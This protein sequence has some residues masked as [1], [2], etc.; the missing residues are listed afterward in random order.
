MSKSEDDVCVEVF[1]DSESKKSIIVP[2]LS[3][4][5]SM[6][7]K[8]KRR[9]RAAKN[10]A[11]ALRRT[12]SLTKNEEQFLMQVQTTPEKIKLPS[13]TED[14]ELS[15][16]RNYLN[17]RIAD[18]GEC[19]TNTEKQFLLDLMN[20]PN[21]TAS[22]LLR[23]SKVLFRDPLFNEEEKKEEHH[24]TV[25][26][27]SFS[28]RN[29]CFR[30]EVWTH[31]QYSSLKDKIMSDLQNQNFSEEL[32]EEKSKPKSP[33]KGLMYRLMKRKKKKLDQFIGQNE[34]EAS[35]NLEFSILGTFALDKECEPHVLSPPMMDVLRSHLPFS[36]KQ[37]NF[38]LKYSLVR[39][40]SSMRVLLDKIRSS[41]RTV[42]AIETVQGDV[43]GSF[44]SSP[45]RPRGK[46]FYGSCEAFLWRMKKS[47]FSN[48]STVD[49]QIALE[50]DLEIFPW[51]GKNRNVQYFESP[52]GKI[53]I[54]GGLPDNDDKDQDGG[55]GLMITS[56]MFHG[57]SNPCHTFASPALP[58][59]SPLDAFEITNMEVWTLTPVTTVENAE[60]LEL[61]RQFIFDHGKFTQEI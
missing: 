48:C 57:F 51:S 7:T 46:D 32:K 23:S 28:S 47:R 45:W 43:F 12:N 59:T 18:K 5:L 13:F 34:N 10:M 8:P 25:G 39:D 35:F 54:G 11:L 41:A 26:S 50:A 17:Q 19:L 36:I 33:K 44:T 37:D 1:E 20:M 29:L 31:Y 9:W 22:Y 55:F 58:T 60:K 27:L 24:I 53:I 4:V 3:S 40:G 2:P 38:W 16:A 15:N 14:E 30:N 49:D 61:G 56:D 52:D 42:I 6:M 21:I